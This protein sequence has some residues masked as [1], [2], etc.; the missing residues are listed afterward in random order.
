MTLGTKGVEL[1][2]DGKSAGDALEELKKS[3]RSIEYR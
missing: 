1:M 2:A 3:D